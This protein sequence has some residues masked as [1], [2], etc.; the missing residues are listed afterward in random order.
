[1]RGR[2]TA[3]GDVRQVLSVLRMVHRS[4]VLTLSRVLTP[5][6]KVGP[7]LSLDNPRPPNRKSDKWR[8]L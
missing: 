4:Q 6:C 1:M 5:H 8:L 7:T 3:R 2:T